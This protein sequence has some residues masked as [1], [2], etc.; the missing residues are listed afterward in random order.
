MLDGSLL[1][2]DNRQGSSHLPQKGA[3]TMTTY[4]RLLRNLTRLTGTWLTLLSDAAR[5]LILCLHPRPALAAENLLLRKQLAQ[6]QERDVKPRRPTPAIRI[7]LTVLARWFDWRQ[8]LVIVQPATLIRWH[9]LGFR[10][11]RIT[12]VVLICLW[13]QASRSHPGHCRF[14]CKR[15]GTDFR[16]IYMWWCIRSLA[17]CIMTMGLQRRWHEDISRVNRSGTWRVS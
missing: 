5:Y 11:F 7:A 3:S 14:L 2:S 6:Y 13:G 9:R 15:T 16:S 10:V 4:Q 12:R 1:S 17:V 8:A